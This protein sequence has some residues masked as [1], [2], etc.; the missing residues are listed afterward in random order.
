MQVT[1][2]E[3]LKTCRYY[4]PENNEDAQNIINHPSHYTKGKYETIEIIED[5]KLNY[6]LGNAVKYISRCEYKN[7]KIEDLKKAIWY[8]NREIEREEKNGRDSG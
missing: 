5:W 8:I 6:H 1:K 2:E 3:E 4:L 7:K